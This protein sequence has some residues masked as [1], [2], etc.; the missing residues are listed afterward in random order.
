MGSQVRTIY[1]DIR[2]DQG[3]WI[4]ICIQHF[5]LF[6][7]YIASVRRG[8][9]AKWSPIIGRLRIETD[10]SVDRAQGSFEG[11]HRVPGFTTGE[12]RGARIRKEAR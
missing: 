1:D 3:S 10:S 7:L 6:S 4:T 5:L 2:K 11:V 12:Q 8:A 9:L